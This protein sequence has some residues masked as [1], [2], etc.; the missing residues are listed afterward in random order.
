M[1]YTGITIRN[2]FIGNFKLLQYKDV[3]IY[4]LIFTVSGVVSGV[5][6]VGSDIG[7]MSMLLGT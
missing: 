3:K 2:Q 6:D 1:F 7:V 5:T 4:F